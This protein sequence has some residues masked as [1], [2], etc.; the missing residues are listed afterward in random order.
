MTPEEKRQLPLPIKIRET[1]QR[2]LHRE[3]RAQCLENELT[4]NKAKFIWKQ[5]KQVALKR[6]PLRKRG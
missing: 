6:Q 1:G 4:E 5:E 3:V 2:Q